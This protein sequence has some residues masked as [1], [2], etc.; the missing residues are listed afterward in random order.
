MSATRTGSFP[1]GFRRGGTAWQKD[2]NGLIAFAKSAGLEFIDLNRDADSAGK[3]VLQAGFK[4]G[5]VDLPD[6][7]GLA[8]PDKA[9]RDK[10]VAVNSEYIRACAALGA[11]YFFVAVMYEDASRSRADNFRLA[12]EGYGA[13]AP[14]LTAADAWVVME[15]WPGATVLV[16]T[17]ETYR[18]FLKECPARLAINYDPSHLIRMG[19]DPI[20]FL[21][22]FAPQVRHMHAKDT[23][24][25]T[26]AL[27]EFGH[28]VPATFTKNHGYGS[29]A[30]RY[31]IPGHGQMRW[32][33]AFAILR[34]AGYRGGV[35]IELE[36]ENFNGTEAGEKEA[37]TRGTQFLAGC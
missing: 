31:T 18:A 33:E 4:L 29:F 15:G 1:I 21:R 2:L 8:S 30:W 25:F 10:A 13:L 16:T 26:E 20:R 36:D 19:I 34:D 37:L 9:K 6:M 22:E 28:E 35:S 5:S 3:A 11:K 14:A 27:Y 23:E 12:V 24:V 32:R 7:Q 17:P